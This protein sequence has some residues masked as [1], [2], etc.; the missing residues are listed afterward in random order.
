MVASSAAGVIILGLVLRFIVWKKKVKIGSDS[1]KEDLELPLYDLATVTSATNNFSYTNMI[2]KGGF[3]PVYKD[4]LP[5]GQEV[6][7][8]R[9]SNNTGQGLQEFKNEVIL[10]SKLQH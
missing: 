3:G 4:T 10:I 7:V 5:V 9:L 8:K 6:A 2:G 1:E